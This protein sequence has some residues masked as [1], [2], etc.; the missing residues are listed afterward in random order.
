MSEIFVCEEYQEIIWRCTCIKGVDLTI[1][2]ERHIVLPVRTDVEI[3][4]YK[5]D[6]RVYK[7]D[8]GTIEIDG[9]NIQ[10]C[11]QQMRLQQAFR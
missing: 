11:L 4:N 10:I 3:N 2:R 5:S 1:K 9:K 7:P 6:F 8:E